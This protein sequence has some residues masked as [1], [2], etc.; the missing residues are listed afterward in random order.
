MVYSLRQFVPLGLEAP[1]GHCEPNETISKGLTTGVKNC[2]SSRPSS[3]ITNS[4]PGSSPVPDTL[5]RHDFDASQLGR[6]PTSSDCGT[7]SYSIGSKC[8]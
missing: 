1:P 8:L 3:Y 4:Q 2:G 5:G 6:V 7:L